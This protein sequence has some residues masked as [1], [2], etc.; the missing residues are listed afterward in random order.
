MEQNYSQTRTSSPFFDADALLM[1]QVV[2]QDYE[3][4][5]VDVLLKNCLKKTNDTI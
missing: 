4:L 1:A 5:L 2:G 3:L